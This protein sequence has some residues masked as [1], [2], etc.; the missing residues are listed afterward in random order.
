MRHW[1]FPAFLSA[2]FGAFF[3][4]AIL[5]PGGSAFAADPL[6]TP[7]AGPPVSQ[8]EAMALLQAGKRQEARQAFAAIIAAHPP[9]PSQALFVASLIALEDDDWRTAQPYVRQLVKLR[10]ASFASWEFMIQVDQAAGAL[11]DRDAAIQSLY[12]AWRSALDPQISAKV[13]F[14]RDRIFGAKHTLLAQETLEP[15]GDDILRFMFQPAEEAGQVR[16][17]IVVRSD[18]ETNERWRE[19]GTVSYGTVV[20]HLDTVDRF[21]DGRALTRPY[22]FYLEPPTYDQVRAKVAA[23]LAG[24]TQPLAGQADPSWAGEP[25]R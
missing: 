12:T 7:L 24:T 23:I 22:A 21:G 18:S 1:F 11:E 9:D 5:V 20:Y 6:T 3:G 10:P 19:D 4:A 25:V 17:L 8:T 2:F 13:A 15:G 14:V 16:H